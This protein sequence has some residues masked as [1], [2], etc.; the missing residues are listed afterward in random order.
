MNLNIVQIGCGVV[1]GAYMRAYKN[2]GFNIMG[3][4]VVDSIIKQLITEGI[5]S[6]HPKSVPITTEADIILV[7]V[8]TPLIVE[9][10]RLDMKYVVSTLPLVSRLVQQST[11]HNPLIMLRSTLPPGRTM[12][13]VEELKEHLPVEFHNSFRIAFQP[14]FLRAKSAYDDAFSP[15]RVVIGLDETHNGYELSK[16]QLLSIFSEFMEDT[17]MIDFLTIE[18]AEFMKLVHNYSNG[19]KISY[20]NTIDSIANS[21]S[22]NI[23]SEK[24]I[25]LVSTTAESFLNREYGLTPGM[26]YGGTCLPKDIPELTMIAPEGPLRDFIHTTTRINDYTEQHNQTKSIIDG[27]NWKSGGNLLQH[28]RQIQSENTVRS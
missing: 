15:W 3:V 25:K 13:Y 11:N 10:Q 17:N 22:A 23:N 20:A 28:A 8:P 1:G 2:R 16:T 7:S 12:Q 4:D 19:L 24:I 21:L 14:E 18:E 9:T 5:Q 27:L 26:P 6:Y